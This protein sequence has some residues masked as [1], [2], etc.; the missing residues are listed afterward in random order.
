MASCL[1]GTTLPAVSHAQ[2]EGGGSLEEVIV[3]AQY[4]EQGVQDVPIAMNAFSSQ[5]IEKA[6]ITDLA[7]ISRLAP[8]FTAIND[9]GFVRLSLR[10]IQSNSTD[11]G[12]DQ[13]MTF[14]IDGDYINRGNFINTAMFDLERVEVLRGPQG[15]LY[16]RNATAGAVNVIARKPTL[17]GL[18]G[19]VSAD[20]GN[21]SSQI[22]NGAINIPLGSRAAIRLAAMSAEHDGY[23]SHPNFRQRT[24]DQ[25]TQAYRAGLLFEPTD[26]L[27][28]YLAAEYGEESFVPS[29]AAANANFAPYRADAPVPGTCSSPGWEAIAVFAPGFGCAP[30]GTDYVGTIDRE[31]YVNFAPW[32]GFR[33]QDTTSYRGSIEY[34]GPIA[35]VY[36]VGFRESHWDGA[37]GLPNLMFYRAEDTDNIS[38][39][40]RFSSTAKEGLFWQAGLFYYREEISS[41]GGL[42]L[43]FGQQANPTGPGIYLNTSYRPDFDSES[44]AAFAQ[45]DLPF[46]GSFTGVLGVRYTQ[47]DKSGTFYNFAGPPA[48]GPG[49]LQFLRPISAANVVTP[50][51]FDH[52]ETTW[53][54][55]VN[56]EPDGDS[57]HYAK[58]SKGYKAGGFDAVGVYAPET[59]LAYEVGSKNQFGNSTFNVAAFYYDYKDLQAAVLLDTSKGA[60]IFNAGKA[61]IYGVEAEYQLN[62]TD[63]DRLKLTAN[64]LS[65]E[66]KTF[67]PLQ[68]SV[69]CVGGCGANTV[70]SD[71]SGN[72][73]PNAPEWILTASYDH[74]WH[75]GAGTLTGSIFSRYKDEYYNTVFNYKDSQQESYTQTDVSLEYLTGPWSVQA[76]GRNLEDERPMNYMNFVS[77]GP[78]NDD[79]NWLF[80]TPRTYGVRVSYTF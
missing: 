28:I 9:V 42:H 4:R 64:Y 61:E 58:V 52:N 65:A 59:M 1:I 76:Y 77:A 35:T 56:Y 15:T 53:T 38:H 37:Q 3:T 31:N 47:D 66:Y 32:L 24:N 7:S 54:V 16:G 14:N 68:E 51:E 73:F 39:E 11:E 75:V 34:T 36:R 78:S 72:R 17:D 6:G 20:A 71:A 67:S 26:A 46:A 50:A 43:P 57:L 40:L 8:D 19:S 13:A 21:Y 18:E 45:V 12:G 29:Y 25:D 2:G 79:F 63:D 23:S 55:G 22:Y 41:R 62:I 60:Q 69:Q 49:G 48:L 5:D 10:G 44:K 74:T 30:Y 27:S 80:G 33:E 70:P